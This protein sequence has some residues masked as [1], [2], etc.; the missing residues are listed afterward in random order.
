MVPKMFPNGP[1]MVPKWSQE[2]SKSVFERKSR[3]TLEITTFPMKM[4]D[5]EVRRGFKMKENWMQEGFG[6]KFEFAKASKLKKI[7]C[8]EGFGSRI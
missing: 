5:F 7:D 1:E 4:F 2:G 6:S 3:K 8:K